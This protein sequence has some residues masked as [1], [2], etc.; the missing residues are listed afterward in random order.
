MNLRDIHKILN[1]SQNQLMQRQNSELTEQEVAILYGIYQAKGGKGVV[2]GLKNE[3]IVIACA[4]EF[5]VN[6]LKI[7]PNGKQSK[8]DFVQALCQR[9]EARVKGV[10]INTRYKVNTESNRMMV[11]ILLEN[12]D[13]C[14]F[15]TGREDVEPYSIELSLG[16]GTFPVDYGMLVE[17]MLLGIM[18]VK[19]CAFANT[20]VTVNMVGQLLRRASA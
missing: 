13:K 3:Q 1:V 17:D 8:S 20:Y 18:G 11:K 12:D 19:G 6:E 4:T 9:L 15:K 10:G 7:K 5:Y 14:I 16:V 2:K